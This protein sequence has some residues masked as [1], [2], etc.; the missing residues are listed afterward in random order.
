MKPNHSVSFHDNLRHF[1]QFLWDGKLVCLKKLPKLSV[2]SEI[3]DFRFEKFRRKGKKMSIKKVSDTMSHCCRGENFNFK[4][5]PEW[6]WRKK[7]GCHCLRKENQLLLEEEKTFFLQNFAS[8]SIF[9]LSWR[10]CIMRVHFLISPPRLF[11]KKFSLVVKQKL[12]VE[13]ISCNGSK[14]WSGG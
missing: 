1:K 4:I 11:M 9:F 5:G 6:S 10:D 12:C 7:T 8:E 13:V 3:R 2:R 14:W